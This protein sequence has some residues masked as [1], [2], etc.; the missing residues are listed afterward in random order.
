MIDERVSFGR[1]SASETLVGQCKEEQEL[2]KSA[3]I[4]FRLC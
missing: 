2:L 3:A 4:T 1:S